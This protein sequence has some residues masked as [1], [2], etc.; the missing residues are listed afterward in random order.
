[1]TCP[2]MFIVCK[3]L[4]DPRESTCQTASTALH[5]PMSHFR[6]RGYV[7]T[8]PHY[9]Q[10][11]HS[12]FSWSY[13]AEQSGGILFCKGWTLLVDLDLHLG[14]EA[15][16]QCD[17][18]IPACKGLTMPLSTLPRPTNWSPR[19]AEERCTSNVPYHVFPCVVSPTCQDCG[20]KHPKLLPHNYNQIHPDIGGLQ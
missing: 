18:P 5:L 7:H 6:V 19:C 16:R 13:T 2:Q 10:L 15:G 17:T 1:M 4:E 12:L 3:Y 9:A 20:T 8:A 11:L 14:G